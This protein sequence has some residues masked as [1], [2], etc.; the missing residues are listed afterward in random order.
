MQGLQD[1]GLVRPAAAEGNAR[2][3]RMELTPQGVESVRMLAETKRRLEEQI[4]SRLGAAETELL[5]RLLR[6]NWLP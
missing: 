1:A 2:D 4:V 3:R 6:E 5:L